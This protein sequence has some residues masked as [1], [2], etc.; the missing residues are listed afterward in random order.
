MANLKIMLA[1]ASKTASAESK[2]L[3][4]DLLQR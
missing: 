3:A 1:A 4:M 2:I